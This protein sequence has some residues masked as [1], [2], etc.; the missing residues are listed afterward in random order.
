MIDGTTTAPAPA[1]RAAAEA[2]INL[3]GLTREEIG[4][5]L[6][7]IGVPERARR[8]RADQLWHWMYFRGARTFAEMTNISKDLRGALDEKFVIGRGDVVSAQTSADGTRKWL[9]GF[10]PG[11]EAESVFIPEEDRGALCVSSQIGCTLNCRFCHT[12]TQALVRNLSAGE[13]VAQLLRARDE[14]GEWPSP[15]GE[16]MLS[17]VVLM[18]MGEPLYN[19]DNVAAALRIFMDHEGIGI[20][21]RRI[22]LSTAGVVP[23]IERAGRELG[24]ALRSRSMPCT[25]ICAMSSSRSTK[26]T[27]SRN[28]STPAAA[29]REPRTHAA[30]PLNM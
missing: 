23:M 10:G 15:A 30:S 1:R 19:Y 4:D 12:G 25:T 29:I 18:G 28:C 13:I 26:S 27:P 14:L 5:A 2:R 21:R 16:R 11:Q 3:V 24:V 17:N 9:I 6:A 8:M 7:R 22:T 20:S